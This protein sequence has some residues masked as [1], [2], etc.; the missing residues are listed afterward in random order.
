LVGEETAID[1]EDSDLVGQAC[2]YNGAIFLKLFCVLFYQLMQN[3][4]KLECSIS[5]YGYFQ[6]GSAKFISDSSFTI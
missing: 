2:S 1:E 3:I 6:S 5:Q 4:L